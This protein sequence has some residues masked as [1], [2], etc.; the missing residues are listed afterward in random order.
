MHREGAPSGAQAQDDGAASGTQR[1][2]SAAV[3]R[4]APHAPWNDGHRGIGDK[5]GCTGM[6]PCRLRAASGRPSPMPLPCPL[7]EPV[8]R[9]A[10]RAAVR[11]VPLFPAGLPCLRRRPASGLVSRLASLF[12][13][14]ESPGRTPCTVTA[15]IRRRGP[16]R[17]H[18]TPVVSWSG[19]EMRALHRD[20]DATGG[21]RCGVLPAIP[22]AVACFLPSCRESLPAQPNKAAGGTPC[23][24]D[25]RQHRRPYRRCPSGGRT[26]CTVRA[27]PPRSWRPASAAG[28]QAR[29]YAP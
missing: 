21:G 3:F 29:P 20:A 19:N 8:C 5:A 25:R 7:G 18:G 22:P 11:R 2:G 14:G 26:S 12:G 24:R 9:A 28:T 27:W 16:A 23:T 10:S 15:P 1:G 4:E 6:H 13:G 17:S